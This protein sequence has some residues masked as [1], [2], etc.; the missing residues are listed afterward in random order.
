MAWLGQVLIFLG[1][2][3]H[4]LV[5]M[6]SKGFCYLIIQREL[7]FAEQKKSE[8]IFFVSWIILYLTTDALDLVTCF[9]VDVCFIRAN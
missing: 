1:I 6:K 4:N 9:S 3:I 5:N 7:Q 2:I 8:R